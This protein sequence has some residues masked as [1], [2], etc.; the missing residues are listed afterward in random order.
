MWKTKVRYFLA[1]SSGPPLLSMYRQMYRLAIGMAVFMFRRCRGI[2]AVYLSRGCSK[3]EIT[4]GISDID[5]ILIVDEDAQGRRQAENVFHL[6]QILTAGLIPYHPVFVLT[7][8][9][10]HYRWQNTPYWRYR[11]QEGK[12]TW[13]LLHGCEVLASLPAISEIERTTSCYA[14]MNYW[15]VQYCDLILQNDRY[16]DDFVMRNSMCYKAVAEVLNARHAMD[17]AEFCYSKDEALRRADSPLSRKLLDTAAKR[18]L[19]ADRTLEKETY[20]FLIQT[21]LDIW[22]GF[23]DNPFLEVYPDVVQELDCTEQDIEKEKLEEPFQEIRRHLSDHWGDMCRGVHLLK[24]AFWKIEES[25]LLIDVDRSSLPTLDDLDRLIAVRK[26][27]DNGQQVPAH[28][29][30][31]LQN[32]AFP[33]TPTLPADYHRGILTPATAP[34]VFLQLGEKNVYWTNHTSWYLTDW[35]RNRQWMDASP[36][37][38]SQLKMIACSA[39]LGHVRYPLSL[40]S[41]SERE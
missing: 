34:D 33:I 6:L 7:E 4:P 20:R 32:V 26:R 40:R 28:F 13:S 18:F 12:S 27:V 3:G 10:L 22:A 29:F 35:L 2:R 25:L 8:E 41:I 5:F 19:R 24:S 9:E 14:E 38:R 37:K 31:R 36:L 39:A 11:L 17:T 15:W 16:R 21:F 23:R 1:W 30:L